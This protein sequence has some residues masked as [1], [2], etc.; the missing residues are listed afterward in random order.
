MGTAWRTPAPFLFKNWPC[1]SY[2][3]H[4]ARRHEADRA[5]RRAVRGGTAQ[6]AGLREVN[7]ARRR[8]ARGGQRKA[9][10]CE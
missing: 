8:A 10:S 9:P 7:S 4:G 1:A 2:S 3:T 6:G 5:R